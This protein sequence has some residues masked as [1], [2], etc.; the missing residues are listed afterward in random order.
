MPEGT[1]VNDGAPFKLVWTETHGLAKAPEPIRRKGAEVKEGFEVSIEPAAGSTSGV[2]VGVLDVMIC[3]VA[4]HRVC[5][6]VK[7]VVG[8][9]FTVDPAADGK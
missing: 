6:P 1:A 5:V 7:R 8:A 9:K 3:D 4:T 2:L